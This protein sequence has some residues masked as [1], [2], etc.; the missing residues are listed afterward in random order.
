MCACGRAIDIS[1][2][3]RDQVGDSLDNNKTCKRKVAVNKRFALEEEGDYE[4]Y[5]NY[6]ERYGFGN[7]CIYGG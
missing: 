6:G 1:R 7:V 4:G 3:T 2:R 5:G